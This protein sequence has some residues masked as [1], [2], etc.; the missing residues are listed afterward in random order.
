VSR[1][2]KVAIGITAAYTASLLALA[3]QCDFRKVAARAKVRWASVDDFANDRYGHGMLVLLSPAAA[4]MV[5]RD[6]VKSM[7]ESSHPGQIS[8][9]VARLK[10]EIR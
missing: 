5:A 8:V 6:K 1:G 10:K 2:A 9:R 3:T 4:V 7:L